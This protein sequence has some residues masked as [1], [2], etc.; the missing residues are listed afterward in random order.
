MKLHQRGTTYHFSLR[1]PSDLI[2]VFNRREIHQSLRT[3]DGRT[4]R[5]R[6]STISSHTKNESYLNDTTLI[7]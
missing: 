7:I 1:A 5:S 6:A 2:D 3:F 4:A